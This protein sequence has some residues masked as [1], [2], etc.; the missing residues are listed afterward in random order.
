MVIG[1]LPQRSLEQE[2][3][4]SLWTGAF[5]VGIGRAWLL[6][7]SLIQRAVLDCLGQ[8]RQLYRLAAGQIRDGTRHLEN[9]TVTAC[10]VPQPV[11]DRL[12]VVS[13]PGRPPC[14]ISDRAGLY[15][16]VGV[17]P[18]RGKSFPLQLASR[19]NPGPDDLRRFAIDRV[20]QI[21]VGNTGHLDVQVDAV[22]IKINLSQATDARQG[23][24][25]DLRGSALRRRMAPPTFLDYKVI[26]R[27]HPL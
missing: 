7:R 17:Q 21:P 22:K 12:P 10:G 13:A 26:L 18:E 19:L 23:R 11:G 25:F 27:F 1:S 3:P 20:R 4:D 16:A 2:S 5:S 9:P 15:L 14:R 6:R 8:G 24:M